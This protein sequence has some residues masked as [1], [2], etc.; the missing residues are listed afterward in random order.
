MF[1]NF[2]VT[3]ASPME[4][5][6]LFVMRWLTTFSAPFR[7]H[8]L[9]GGLVYALFCLTIAQIWALFCCSTIIWMGSVKLLVV[10]SFASLL[11]ILFFPLYNY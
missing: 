5:Y 10:Y 7:V 8:K 3:Y 4:V 9:V 6:L 1:T 11:F 2:A